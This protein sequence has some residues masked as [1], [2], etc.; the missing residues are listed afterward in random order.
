MKIPIR[1]YFIFDRNIQPELSPIISA[2]FGI[3]LYIYDTHTT[4]FAR[5]VV[6]DINIAM[7]I[8]TSI[9]A[10]FELIFRF[11]LFLCYCETSEYEWKK[12]HQK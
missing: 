11:V 6:V 10:L 1:I 5:Y 2:T 8:R 3:F 7:S 4:F 12:C 9:G